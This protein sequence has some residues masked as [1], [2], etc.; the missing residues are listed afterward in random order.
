MM[1]VNVKS[2]SRI[3]TIANKKTALTG[4]TI[5]INDD[6]ANAIS[7]KTLNSNITKQVSNHTS[8]YFKFS[9]SLLSI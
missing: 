3:K 9:L 7:G 2:I 8:V 4:S 6:I 5:P 1:I